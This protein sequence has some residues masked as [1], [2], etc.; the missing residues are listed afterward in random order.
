[1]PDPAVPPTAGTDLQRLPHHIPGSEV[2]RMPPKTVTIPR[3]IS[4]TAHRRRRQPVSV[5][6]ITTLLGLVSVIAAA[7]PAHGSGGPPTD[8]NNQTAA[9]LLTNPGFE[10]DL[11]HWSTYGG[12]ARITPSARSGEQALAMGPGQGG[13]SQSIQLKPNTTYTVSAW[14]KRV[15]STDYAQV[16]LAVTDG[17]GQ[18]HDYQMPYS[19]DYYTLQGQVVTTPA[20]IT[21]A[22]I[23][24]QKNAGSGDFYVDDVSVVK[25][26]DPK[27]WPF[28]SSSIW[29][30]PIGSGARY[31]P[32]GIEQASSIT[33]DPSYFID[34]S[35]MNADD[36]TSYR[37]LTPNGQRNG[38]NV[39]R[40]QGT[41]D[42]GPVLFPKNMIVPDGTVQ[43]YSTPNNVTAV[44]QP[45]GRSIQQIQPLARCTAGANV[46]GYRAR[47]DDLYGDGTYG[48]HFGSGLSSIGGAIRPG[49]LTD[50]LPIRHA[51]QLEVW[52]RRYLDFDR[53]SPT[54]GFRWP[55]DSADGYA[56][57]TNGY[58]SM[59]PCQTHP[60]PDLV[61]G[62]LL[63]LPPDE[64]AADLGL[65]SDAGKKLFAALQQFGGYIVDDTGYTNNAIAVD[66]D[67]LPGFN[68]TNAA[69]QADMQKLF[70]HLSVV[71]NNGPQN[72]GGGGTP[73][74]SSAPALS[75]PPTPAAEPLDRHAWTATAS[76]N[77]AA[78]NAALDGNDATAWRTNEPLSA[79]QYIQ[80][81][82]RRRT[83][84]RRIRMDSGGILNGHPQNY[85]IK[86][87]ND[88]IHWTT[89][90]SGTGA[91][92]TTMSFPV[93]RARYLR[94]ES[95]GGGLANQPQEFVVAELDLY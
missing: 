80:V 81:D 93:Q 60:N 27:I 32:A 17:A 18:R 41:T 3:G 5:F 25:G 9:N 72:I 23:Y 56:G 31:L 65:T 79:G 35:T 36:Y 34:L 92:V 71:A 58:C 47:E 55:A 49:E 44:G 39:G 12:G 33:N 15:D 52:G 76:P 37:L 7:S 88:G 82:L 1:M 77:P 64:S 24:I 48:A 67:A 69:F 6:A 20:T 46:H 95:A 75:T 30:T 74:T 87:S 10:T 66:R 29:N 45:D 84:V 50:Q 57:G 13:A 2:P 22:Q 11:S 78:A 70:T 42:L 89:V 62:S 19:A 68:W 59:D 73:I 40:C 94:I 61:Q 21:G 14:A 38:N 51:L 26:R 63:A 85:T 53:S 83:E 90:T 54:P 43:P 91:P 28:T 16:S 4:S 86:T 8:A